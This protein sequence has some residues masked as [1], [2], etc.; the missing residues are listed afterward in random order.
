MG[1][2]FESLCLF[3]SIVQCLGAALDSQE[4]PVVTQLV[5][6]NR[7]GS[8]TGHSSSEHLGCRSKLA[9]FNSLL[10]WPCTGLIWQQQREYWMGSPLDLRIWGHIEKLSFQRSSECQLQT[11]RVLNRALV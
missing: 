10:S 7:V 8:K 5:T 6:R 1:R 3:C 11:V 2:V 9:A 4:L